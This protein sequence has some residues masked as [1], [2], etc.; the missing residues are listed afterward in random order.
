MVAILRD[1]PYA[2][3]FVPWYAIR[4]DVLGGGRGSV[5]L[6]LYPDSLAGVLEVMHP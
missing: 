3:R 1:D 4:A 5:R 6:E 2:V